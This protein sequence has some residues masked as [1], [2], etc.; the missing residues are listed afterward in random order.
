MS[1]HEVAILHEK[2]T[3]ILQVLDTWYAGIPLHLQQPAVS[4][5][6]H[7]GTSLNTMYY[8][9]KE[10]LLRP[11]VYLSIHA[12]SI[13]APPSESDMPQE[14]L[15]VYYAAQIRK[16]NAQHRSAAVAY[17][18]CSLCAQE[19]GARAPSWS[20]TGWLQMYTCMAVALMLLASMRGGCL[21]DGGDEADG[22]S[23]QE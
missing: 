17:I 15:R 7:Y 18:N 11:Y 6:Q 19:Q 21:D 9:T 12:E 1:L 3:S 14:A 2:L 10:L 23:L 16:M 4:A 22:S 5:M 13:Q 8:E 20:G